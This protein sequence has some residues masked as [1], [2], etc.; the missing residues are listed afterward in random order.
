MV[1]VRECDASCKDLDHEAGHIGQDIC[2]EVADEEVVHDDG[3]T[4][5]FLGD[6]GNGRYE[7]MMAGYMEAEDSVGDYNTSAVLV[8]LR[9]NLEKGDVDDG[10]HSKQGGGEVDETQDAIHGLNA[11]RSQKSL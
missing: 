4:H 11:R 1:A 5:Y 6:E 9:W 7:D 3:H 8:I 2:P 10:L